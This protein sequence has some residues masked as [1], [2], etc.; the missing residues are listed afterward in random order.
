MKLHTAAELETMSVEEAVVYF[1]K[2]HKAH[3]K[4]SQVQ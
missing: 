2:L 3:A 1:D 4:E